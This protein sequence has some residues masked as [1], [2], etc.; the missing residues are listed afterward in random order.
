MLWHVYRSSVFFHNK[1]TSSSRV[2]EPHK[3]AWFTCWGSDRPPPPL[4][5]A[6]TLHFLWARVRPSGVINNH[7]IEWG[8]VK[9]PS[10]RS[11]FPLPFAAQHHKRITPRFCPFREQLECF[12]SSALLDVPWLFL[13]CKS[14]W[15]NCYYNHVSRTK[16]KAL[17]K[18]NQS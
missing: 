6:L 11:A 1:T 5:V 3:K 15:L 8:K 7:S 14:R 13:R 4:P 2:A 16:K 9:F 17:L 18:W 12:V 10:K